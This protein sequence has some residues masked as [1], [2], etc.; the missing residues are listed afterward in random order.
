MNIQHQNGLV[1]Q[2]PPSLTHFLKLVAGGNRSRLHTTILTTF[3]LSFKQ[4]RENE[5]E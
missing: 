4:Q 1:V 2:F 5:K 3:P